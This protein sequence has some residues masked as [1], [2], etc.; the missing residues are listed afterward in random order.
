MLGSIVSNAVA[1]EP[2]KVEVPSKVNFD[3]F[4]IMS[5]EVMVLYRNKK[6]FV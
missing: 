5:Q 4:M 6:L 1:E 2:K 3:G